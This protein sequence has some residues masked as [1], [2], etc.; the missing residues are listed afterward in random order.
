MHLTARG[1]FSVLQDPEHHGNS[2][3]VSWKTRC[4]LD[5]FDRTHDHRYVAH[6]IFLYLIEV[7]DISFNLKIQHVTSL[8]NFKVRTDQHPG[9]FEP[10]PHVSFEQARDSIGYLGHDVPRLGGLY[11]TEPP[12]GDTQSPW[13]PKCNAFRKAYAPRLVNKCAI[14]PT[15]SSGSIDSG[16]CRRCA[17]VEYPMATTGEKSNIVR[18][19]PGKLSA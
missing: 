6:P 18:P 12:D 15:Y 2:M 7:T 17:G 14:N 4:G 3:A 8:A 10:R 13:A 19:T 5:A 9:I 11:R 1:R 16:C